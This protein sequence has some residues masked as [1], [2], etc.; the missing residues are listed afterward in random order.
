MHSTILTRCLRTTS[1]P[2][3][4][5]QIPRQPQQL[6]G[7]S[8]KTTRAHSTNPD[9]LQ[10]KENNK[11]EKPAANEAAAGSNNDSETTTTTSSSSS[12]TNTESFQ[13]HKLVSEAEKNK[14]K[15][16][17]LLESLRLKRS[18]KALNSAME[19]LSRGIQQINAQPEQRSLDRENTTPDPKPQADESAPGTRIELNSVAN[20]I[21]SAATNAS[22]SDRKP[23]P[24]IKTVPLKLG[25]KL[26]RQITVQND[27]GM[28]CASAIRTLESSCRSNGLR[29]QEAFQR[30]HVR[31]GQLRKNLRIQRWRKL[32]KFSFMET[33]KK[34]D[35]MRD[36]GW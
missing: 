16:K 30:F 8:P 10:E 27:R 28:D 31:R 21:S 2:L 25:P 18:D 15:T 33:V 14:E 3:F 11:P 34:I 9:P 13:A 7:W 6:S 19:S 5:Q 12:A 26:G 20:R 23:K 29:R 22:A 36:Q 32:F 35:R 24:M 1:L 4:R 17:K